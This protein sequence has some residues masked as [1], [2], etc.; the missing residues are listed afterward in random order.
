[1]Q[2]ELKD[3]LGQ[4]IFDLDIFKQLFYDVINFHAGWAHISAEIPSN[5]LEKIF[6]QAG[7]QSKEFS[8]KYGRKSI[9]NS[10]GSCVQS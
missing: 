10:I 1:M 3:H 9:M 5:I 7:I 8:T 4:K 2:V 6:F